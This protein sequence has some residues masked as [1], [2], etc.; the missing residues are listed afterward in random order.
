MRKSVPD[1]NVE[2]NENERKK[3]IIYVPAECNGALGHYIIIIIYRIIL[4]I[5]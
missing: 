2:S 5:I 1:R 4:C 3:I